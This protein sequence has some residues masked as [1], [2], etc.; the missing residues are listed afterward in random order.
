M[1]R[2]WRRE[3]LGPKS[4]E[5]TRPTGVV[6]GRLV[7]DARSDEGAV[8]VGAKTENVLAETTL[9]PLARVFLNICDPRAD[10]AEPIRPRRLILSRWF[11]TRGKNEKEKTGNLM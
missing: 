2:A 5:W 10:A 8:T 4:I 1:L 7:H 11:Y 6:A 9:G 3:P